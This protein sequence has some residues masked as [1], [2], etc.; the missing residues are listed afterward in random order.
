MDLEKVVAMFF[1]FSACVTPKTQ[2]SK[3]NMET[4]APVCNR[5]AV[6]GQPST[7]LLTPVMNCSTTNAVNN[8]DCRL[9][10]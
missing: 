1:G 9:K 3:T 8:K 4:A 5:A 10:P 6:M 2:L 7:A